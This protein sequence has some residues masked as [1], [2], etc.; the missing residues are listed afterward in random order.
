MKENRMWLGVKK[1]REAAWTKDLPRTILGS[2]E[3]LHEHSRLDNANVHE[4][5][6]NKQSEGRYIYFQYKRRETETKSEGNSE[7][8]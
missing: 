1:I 6:I 8:D 7:E 5:N 3:E 2:V 4:Q